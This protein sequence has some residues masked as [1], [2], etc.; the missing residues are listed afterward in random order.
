[1]CRIANA[2]LEL[3]QQSLFTFT[4]TRGIY[5]SS[6]SVSRS[7]V[8]SAPPPEM[9]FTPEPPL[10]TA[11]PPLFTAEPRRSLLLALAIPLA[12]VLEAVGAL[13]LY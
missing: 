3:T 9:L 2:N 5:R 11:E 4:F 13:R 7:G 1:M 12:L 8:P 6:P 10:F